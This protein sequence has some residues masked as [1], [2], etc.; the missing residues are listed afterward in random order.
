ML[1]VNNRDIRKMLEILEVLESYLLTLNIFYTLFYFEHVVP[2][3]IVKIFFAV[4]KYK[5]FS[6]KII[7]KFSLKMSASTTKEKKCR[8]I[9]IMKYT[10][11]VNNLCY[12][13]LLQKLPLKMFRDLTSKLKFSLLNVLTFLTLLAAFCFSPIVNF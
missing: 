9:Q 12:F 13:M 6:T 10:G 4:V 3:R 5:L 8:V 7:Y 11:Y 2:T 1:K